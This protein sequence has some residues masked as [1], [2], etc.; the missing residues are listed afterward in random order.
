MYKLSVNILLLIALCPLLFAQKATFVKEVE[1]DNNTYIVWHSYVI[2]S[3]YWH[4]WNPDG[5]LPKRSNGTYLYWKADNNGKLI[6][7]RKIDYR[8]PIFQDQPIVM[9]KEKDF[10]NSLNIE[11]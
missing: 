1:V 6:P 7:L 11:N 8:L 9:K 4:V 5:T 2:D 10:Y 3:T